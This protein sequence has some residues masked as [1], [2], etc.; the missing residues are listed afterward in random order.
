[1]ALSRYRDALFG[2]WPP[3]TRDIY[4]A[5]PADPK[6]GAILVGAVPAEGAIRAEA[7]APEAMIG[8]GTGGPEKDRKFGQ[9]DAATCVA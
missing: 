8:L 2:E 5:V 9:R 1:M 7:V 4:H 6:E 3:V